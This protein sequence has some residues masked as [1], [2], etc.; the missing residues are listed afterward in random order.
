MIARQNQLIISIN[1][2]AIRTKSIQ[3]SVLARPLRK[4]DR[5]FIM[6]NCSTG[7]PGYKVRIERRCP[8]FVNGSTR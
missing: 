4:S 3:S 7:W 1:S 6:L 2:Q 5:V 8:P